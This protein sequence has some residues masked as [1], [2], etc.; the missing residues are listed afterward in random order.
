MTDVISFFIQE[1]RKLLDISPSLSQ[2]CQ[3]RPYR[4]SAVQFRNC[5]IAD[6][7]ERAQIAQDIG[8]NAFFFPAEKIPGCDLLSDSG[9]TTMT[10][11]QWSQL[12]LGD[13]AY[14]AN[15]GYSELKKQIVETFGDQWTQQDKQIENMFI[16]HQGRSAEHALFTNLA[17]V[18]KKQGFNLNDIIIPN[19]SHFDTTQANIEFEQMQAIN[20]PCPEH[21]NN[22]EQFAFRGNMDTDKLKSLLQTSADKIPIVYLTI[23]NNTVGGQPVSM[24]NIKKIREIT[25]AYQIP[26][27][28]DASRF[29]ENAWFIKHKEQEYQNKPITEIVQEVF[30]YCD[31][32]HAS[33]KKD[34]LVNIGGMIVIKQDGLFYQKYPKFWE[35]LTDHQILI[36]GNPSYGGLA[37]RDLKALVQGLKTVVQDEYL[38]YRIHQVEK[39][40]NKLIEYKI[41]I[42]RPIGGHAVYINMDKFFHTSV[43]DEDFKGISFVA[44][45]L[46]AGHRLCELGLYAFGKYRNGKEIPPNPRVNYVRA[47]VPRLVY[48]DQDLLACVE[49]VK[50]LYEHQNKIPGV[51]VIYGRDLPL[52]HFKSRFTFKNK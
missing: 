14:G 37:G 2:F 43:D 25:S 32:F 8:L 11:E 52:R 40:G 6:F 3:P 17:R 22:D 42:I 29:A 31:G 30:K 10:I 12:L 51:Q 33:F 20:L 48:E 45:M 35:R 47:A 36:E 26:F 38:T 1:F 7:T 44:L 39:F 16:F 46:V 24:A 19:N 21:L 50:I 41:P 15:Q 18:L 28:M 34:G 4:N 9:T 5:S 27:F 13:E 23:T 49:A